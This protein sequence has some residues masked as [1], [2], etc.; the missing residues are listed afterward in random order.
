MRSPS[1]VPSTLLTLARSQGGIVT[2]KQC[3]AHD[4][5]ATRRH[6]LVRA[7]VWQHPARGVY[8]TGARD[9]ALHRY[10]QERWRTVWLA[11]CAFP[12]A[13]ALG[14]IALMLHGAHGLP[15]R[16]TA[17]VAL[18]GGTANRSRAGVTVRQTVVR[19]R[20][21]R[22]KGR[23]VVGPDLALVQAMRTLYRDSW[24][25]CADS[26]VHQKLVA[27]DLTEVARLAR[28]TGPA[29]SPRWV[30]LVDG[31]SESPL[32]T[33]ARLQCHDAG[34]PPDDLQRDFYDD[35]GRF[36]GR[37]DLAWHLGANRWLV[38]E[39]DGRAHHASNDQLNDDSLRQNALLRDGL[40][41]LLRFR[42]RHLIERPGIAGDIAS[43]L[44]SEGWRPRRTIPARG[45]MHRQIQM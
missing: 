33:E 39:I 1:P 41:I 26:L 22:I 8:D 17:E 25:K 15:L 40:L 31:R 12:R 16:L 5:P 23:S 11:L 2:S 38:V 20:T 45:T 35:R 21:V 27:S 32:E 29:A 44:R 6:R 37:A 18:P 24:V 43:V 7:G 34:I 42:S 30:R 36:L 14:E 9:P 10:D 13:I 19:E 28:R 3:D 4:I